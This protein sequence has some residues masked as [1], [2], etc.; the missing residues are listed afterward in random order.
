MVKKEIIENIKRDF[1][2]LIENPSFLGLM[3]YGSQIDD[4]QTNR[5]DIDLCIILN[6]VDSKEIF[7]NLCTKVDLF[8]KKYDIHFFEE[9]PWYIRGDILEKGI[10]V[11]SSDIPLLFEFLYPYRKIW[12]D[13]KHR[14]KLS[15]KEMHEVLTH[16]IK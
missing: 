1:G 6:K 3:L 16:N 13:Q 10:V 8:G 14:H 4:L 9:L 5:S 12:N 7:N 2:F 11:L 15:K